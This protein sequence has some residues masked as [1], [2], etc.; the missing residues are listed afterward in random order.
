[1]TKEQTVYIAGFIDGEGTISMQWINNRYCTG[2][3]VQVANT[4][5]GVID[6]ISEVTEIG[7]KA[8]AYDR[9][10]EK[11]KKAYLLQ[12]RG[13]KA[14]ELLEQIEPYLIV[15]KEQA[16]VLMDMW[17]WE[18]TINKNPDNKWGKQNQMPI[19]VIERRK[20]TLGILRKLNRKGPIKVEE[21]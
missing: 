21:I 11:Q 5:K 15:K 2:P 1:M 9:H 17:R 4:H 7:H 18:Q 8:Y 14:I 6:W 12:Y 3:F 20:E 10:P 19:E 13:T 16:K